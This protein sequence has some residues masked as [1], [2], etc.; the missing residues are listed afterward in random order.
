MNPFDL[1]FFVSIPWTPVPYNAH[2]VPILKVKPFPFISFS[3]ELVPEKVYLYTLQHLVSQ[4][5]K[6]K[7]GKVLHSIC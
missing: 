2:F 1:T 7:E 4:E 6:K 3:L 5:G